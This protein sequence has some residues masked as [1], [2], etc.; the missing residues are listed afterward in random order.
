MNF[1]WTY[2]GLAL[3]STL[4]GL[5]IT[6]AAAELRLE[7]LRSPP[8]AIQAVLAQTEDEMTNMRVYEQASP[9]VVGIET[10]NGFGSGSIVSPDGLILTSAH[11]VGGDSV[12]TVHLT[13]GRQ[14]QGDVVGYGDVYLD[15]AAVKLRGNLLNLPTLPIAAANSVRVG[16]RAFAIGSPLGLE[17]SFTVGIIS[18]IN[19]KLGLIQTDAATNPGNSGGPLLNCDGELIG[20]SSFSTF[21][22]INIAFSTDQVNAFLTEVR[23]GTAAQTAFAFRPRHRRISINDPAVQGQL[24]TSSYFLPDGSL[25]N[26]YVFKGQLGQSIT[27]EMESSDVD[28]YLVLLSLQ[29]PLILIP[30]EDNDSGDFRNARLTAQLPCDGTYMLLATTF[31][32]SETGQYRL[33]LSSNYLVEI[34]DSLERNDPTLDDGSHYQEHSFEG[35]A[36]QFVRI[37]LESDDFDTYLILLDGGHNFIAENDDI[38][39]DN[40]NSLLVGPLPYDGLFYILVNAYD[41]DGLGR[42]RLTVE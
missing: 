8:W 11:V 4:A 21:T 41:S 22:G 19:D 9:A 17:G 13:N 3:I 1:K 35:Q 7:N 24:D 27:V 32:P 2:A 16:Q 28:A 6:T 38:A 33:S 34:A 31:K 20:V 37:S 26:P 42:Y 5:E 23:D 15:L 18:R 10:S 30:V 14:V 40:S 25:F 12:V 36:G 39:P 29:G